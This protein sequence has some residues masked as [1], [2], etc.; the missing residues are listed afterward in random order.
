MIVVAQGPVGVLTTS[1]VH[2]SNLTVL[3][4]SRFASLGS[5]LLAVLLLYLKAL[6]IYRVT[7]LKGLNSS[8]VVIIL[9][10]GE[11]SSR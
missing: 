5:D 6:S 7:L 1:V 2:P 10:D 4:I 11:P 9:R 8:L 3:V